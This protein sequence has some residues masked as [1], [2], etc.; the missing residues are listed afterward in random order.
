[1]DYNLIFEDGLSAV[2]AHSI[3]GGA[4]QSALRL[5]DAETVF[6]FGSRPRFIVHYDRKGI[7]HEI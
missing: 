7:K 4:A 1:M 6:A 3:G 5:P 2:L